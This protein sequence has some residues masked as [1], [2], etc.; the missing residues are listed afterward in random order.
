VLTL[1]RRLASLATIAAMCLTSLVTCA[2]WGGTAEARMACCE[3]AD[4]CP[5]H[6]SAPDDGGATSRVSQAQAD[7]CCATSEG[8]DSG[9]ST[10]PVTT[11]VSLA[12]VTSPVPDI[13]HARHVFHQGWRTVVPLHRSP[14]PKHLLLSVFLV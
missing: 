10:S 9:T 7:S 1:A 2:G 13:D 12:L 5:M 8:H 4:I 11:F 6:H 3:N 14:V